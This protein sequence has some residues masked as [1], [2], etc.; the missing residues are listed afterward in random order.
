[1]TKRQ[2]IC[3][4]LLYGVDSALKKAH[5]L[6]MDLRDKLEQKIYMSHYDMRDEDKEDYEARKRNGL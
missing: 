4:M 2:Q 5:N 6:L 1:M 3:L